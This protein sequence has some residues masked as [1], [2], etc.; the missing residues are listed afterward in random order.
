MNS[1]GAKEDIAHGQKLLEGHMFYPTGYLVA[2]LP[3]REVAEHARNAV[4]GGGSEEKDCLVMAAAEVADAAADELEAQGVIAALG[5][6]AQVRQR[7]LELAEE[8][9]AFLMIKAPTDEIRAH[10]LN[11]LSHFPVR[12]AVHYHSLTI[13]DLIPLIPSAT[14]DHEAARSP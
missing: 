10:V 3:G 8:G 1:H 14:P 9:C 5:S 7:Q 11:S 2:A 13:E 12:Y 6:S 4:I